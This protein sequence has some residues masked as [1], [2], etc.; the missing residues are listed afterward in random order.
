[1]IIYKITCKVNGKSYIGQ[2]HENIERRFARHMGYQK[3]DNDTKFYRAVNKYG[4]E[5]FY[6]EQIDT[7]NTQEELD[8]KEIYW[9]KYYDTYKNGYNSKLSKGRCGGDTL[10]NHPN[11]EIISEKIRQSK[12]GDKNPMRRNGGLKAERNGMYG[13]R[14]KEAPSSRSCVAISE[15][16]KH[17]M[18]FDTLSDIKNYFNVTTLG[19]VTSR[20]RGCTK[21]PYKGYYF[22]YAE[23]YEK[24]SST[25]ETIAFDVANVNNGVEYIQGVI[26][27]VE[28][29]GG[30]EQSLSQ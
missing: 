5:N 7:A 19:M 3:N 26:P 14:G 23:D 10:S 20:C 27:W 2:T 24:S 8:D 25:I 28:V 6:I 22:K 11:K 12:I 4:V 21:S 30:S 18:Y 15:D 17:V 13:R 9:I 1:M 16:G 29:R